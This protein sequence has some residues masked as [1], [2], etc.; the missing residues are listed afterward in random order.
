MPTITNY[1]LEDILECNYQVSGKTTLIQIVDPESDFP[2]VFKNQFENIY[3][4][5]FLDIEEDDRHVR[6]WGIS[7]EQA[8]CLV[9]ILKEALADSVN[10]IVHCHAGICRSG[11]VVEVGTI[12]GFED[13]RKFRQ[14]NLLVKYKMMKVLG[15]TYE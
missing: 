8:E 11:A 15:L 3:K 12:M 6:E 7:D 5:R 2:E 4:F 9:R 13:C 10:V 14:P 1:S